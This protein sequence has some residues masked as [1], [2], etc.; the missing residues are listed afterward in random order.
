[1]LKIS[2]IVDFQQNNVVFVEGEKKLTHLKIISRKESLFRQSVW[3]FADFRWNNIVYMQKNCAFK[4]YRPQQLVTKF[5][6][7]SI[8]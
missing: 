4:K 1:M 3:G 6:G 8:K 7:F 2:K 5:C